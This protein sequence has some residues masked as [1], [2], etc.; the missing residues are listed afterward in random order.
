[1]S[2]A[3]SRARRDTQLPVNEKK[4]TIQ[5]VMSDDN[6]EDHVETGDNGF[7]LTFPFG[8]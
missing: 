1:M 6:Y 4:N 8:A 5:K 3:P 7:M 2:W